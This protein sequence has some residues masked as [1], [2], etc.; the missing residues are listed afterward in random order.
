MIVLH[1]KMSKKRK[2][3][4]LTDIE[5]YQYLSSIKS[6]SKKWTTKKSSN[7]YIQE[8]LNGA[9]KRNTGKRGEPDLIYIN[10][11]RR[12]LILIENKH[13]INDHQSE[14]EHK[15]TKY[16]VDG[17]THYLS[18]FTPKN[19][20]KHSL[21]IR[22]YFENWSVVGIA[23][24]GDIHDE[25]NHLISTFIITN[26]GNIKDI[27]TSE[28]L[29]EED[30]IAFFENIDVESISKN[31]AKSSSEINRLLRTLNSQDRP[32]L[33]SALMICLYDKNNFSND[34]KKS[35]SQWS[36]A[37]I[38]R[39]IPTTI[40]DILLNEGIDISKINILINELSFVKTDHDLNNSDILKVI[41]K[42]LEENVIPLFNKRTNYDIIGKFYEEFLRY[43]GVANVKK[44]IVLTPSHI[45]QLF[46][47]LIDIK[48]NDVILDTCCGTGTFLIAGMNK[49]LTIIEQSNLSNKKQKI[50]E[51]KQNQL[52]GLEKSTTMYS[53]AISNML[54]RGDGKSR[55]FNVDAFSENAEKILKNLSNEG[56]TPSIGFINP[57]YGGRANKSNPT[58]KEIQFLEYLLDRVSRFGIIIAPLSTY[59]KDNI[60]RNRIL[61]KHTL[62]YVV[63]MPK[64]L[65]QPNAATHTAIAVFETNIPHNDKTVVF[66]NLLEDG[67]VLSKNRGRSDVLNKWNTIKKAFLSKLKN[68]QLEQ[69]SIHLVTTPIKANDEW[70]IQAHSKTDYSHIS[71]KIFIQTLK[72]HLIFTLKKKFNL[73]DKDIDVITL[74]E[75]LN[76]SINPK[77]LLHQ[78][79]KLALNKWKEFYFN[80]IFDFKRGSRLVKLNQIEGDIAYISSTKENNGI[81]NYILPPED[82]TVYQNVLTIN[83]S[84][85]VGYV[86]YHN[87]KI[88]CSDHCTIISVK[89]D[90]LTDL[91][92]YIALFL[93]P[94]IEA[95]KPKYNFAREISDARLNKEKILLPIKQKNQPDWAYMENYIKSLPYSASL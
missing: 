39:N 77:A 36:I 74:M 45:T 33:L 3:E 43:A 16:A 73:L 25:Y 54:F 61:S 44:G 53:L 21:T 12:L 38:I 63:N 57:P 30:Y 17:I 66:Y 83:N 28:I 90:F 11:A 34:F 88:V 20:S 84:G 8:I 37:N 67:F 46:T 93:I 89:K 80:E 32:V 85:S 40:S 95:M 50:T 52:I 13:S 2:N 69:D 1:Q 7:Q 62:K 23:F 14:N 56:I 92:K 26:E 68:P 41:L 72:K 59:F 19:L 15:P 86:F 75:I 9:S 91:N 47:E 4:A 76:D 5:L 29:D 60:I 18:F 87:Y 58:K 42:E 49:L 94:L 27:E 48:T 55:I 81:D 51:I 71:E 24:S 70:I 82:M 78:N 31:I 64:D 22:N 35:Y 10:E 79:K 6:Y 65:F